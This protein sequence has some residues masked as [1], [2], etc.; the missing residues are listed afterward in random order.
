MKIQ[1]NNKESLKGDRIK[2]YFNTCDS[3]INCIREKAD[4][5]DW[6]V[7]SSYIKPEELH[8]FLDEFSS[9]FNIQLY[10]NLH[11]VEGMSMD[12]IKKYQSK[13]SWMQ[14][15]N[16]S[17]MSKVDL[18]KF[19]NNYFP[20]SGVT[21]I[22]YSFYSYIRKYGCDTDFLKM[23]ENSLPNVKE[24]I[25]FNIITSQKLSKKNIKAFVD[26]HIDEDY[27][28]AEDVLNNF[29]ITNEVVE[30]YLDKFFT[31]SKQ[32]NRNQGFTMDEIFLGSYALKDNIKDK[33]LIKKITI[34]AAEKKK[35]TK[36]NY[37]LTS[38]T[39]RLFK[40]TVGSLEKEFNFGLDSI[41]DDDYFAE[42]IHKNYCDE[43]LVNE[44]IS[45]HQMGPKTLEALL[46]YN[47]PKEENVLQGFMPIGVSKPDKK[48]LYS[49]VLSNQKLDPEMEKKY[50]EKYLFISK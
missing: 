50:V 30:S 33:E 31:N 34:K 26:N 35:W 6:S 44:L 27:A 46:S 47:P 11:G 32:K 29:S 36:F 10:S 18:R 37:T 38:Y 25:Y 41:E 9:E 5:I 2:N 24:E 16:N 20:T 15:I 49:G 1:K 3:E 43:G 40:Q 4:Q 21:A 14:V 45:Y 7:F 42:I 17:Q 22:P 19:K 23:F 39:P 13:I 28:Y 12:M 48:S 8:I